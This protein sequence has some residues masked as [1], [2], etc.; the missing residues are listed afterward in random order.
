[1]N[2]IPVLGIPYYNRP[3]LLARCIASID[4]P[5]TKL[6][7][8]DNSN[9]LPIPQDLCGDDRLENLIAKI[10][11]AFVDEIEI[12]RHPNSGVAGAWNE[13]IKLFPADWWLISNSDIEFAP[14]DLEHMAQAV[15]D[16]TIWKTP[17]QPQQ[18]GKFYGNHGA[19]FFAITSD[20]IA[21]VG[22]FDENLYPAYL[23]DC[24]Y[25]RRCDLLNVRRF[26]VQGIFSRHGDEK[27][28]GS[29]TVNA[30]PELQREGARTHD[31]NFSYYE[32]K[33]GGRNGDEVFKTPF[34][35]AHWP[36]WAW[37]YIPEFR[38][39]QQWD[40]TPK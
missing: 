1:M 17:S 30:T 5:V 13:I 21:D 34:N 8:I 36:L 2:T 10:V 16:E 18:P 9:G 24:D 3:D 26:N 25:S 19:S 14:G 27:Q 28:S 11:P 31:N 15:T 35:Q 23:E 6:V 4:C 37:K 32:G 20:C 29:C 38:K 22:L 7:I 39:L 40:L 12:V 33:W